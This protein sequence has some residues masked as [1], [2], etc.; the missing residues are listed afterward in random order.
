M[1]HRT[2]LIENREDLEAILKVIYNHAS[3]QTP[4]VFTKHSTTWQKITSYGFEHYLE[5]D[6]LTVIPK[7]PYFDYMEIVRNSDY[8]V[9]DGG[10]LQED[11]FF[12]GIPTIVHRKRTERQDGIGFNAELSGLETEKVVSFLTHHKDKKEF[13]RTVEGFSPS[14]VVTDTFENNHYFK[15]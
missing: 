9:T 4:V 8:I 1:L 6:G 5:K 11:A 2:E 10:G 12:L 3:P 13:T 14:E 15:K 7:Q